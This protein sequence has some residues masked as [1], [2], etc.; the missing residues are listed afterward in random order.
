MNILNLSRLHI[1][2]GVLFVF[3]VGIQ[4]VSYGLPATDSLENELNAHI[5]RNGKDSIAINMLKELYRQNRY[6]DPYQALEYAAR[7]IRIAEHLKDSAE[8]ANL[9]NYLGD[10]HFDRKIYFLAMDCYSKAYRIFSN[11]GYEIQ[12]AYSLINIG[13]TYAAQNLFENA[14][15]TYNDAMQIFEINHFAEGKAAVWEKEGDIFL[16]QEKQDKAFELFFDVLKV[17]K[18]TQKPGLIAK[19]YMNL[20]DVFMAQNDY[21]LAEQNLL[22][23]LEIYEKQHEPFPVAGIYAKFGDVYLKQKKYELAN[24]C[25]LKSYRIYH[26]LKINSHIARINIKIGYVYL[27]R[28]RYKRAVEHAE[29]ALEA[30]IPGETSEELPEQKRD[31]Y[32]LLSEIFSTMN[33]FEKALEYHRKYSAVK[34]TIFEQI[35]REQFAEFQANLKTE[36]LK[37]QIKLLR[38]ESE[39]KELLLHKQRN[40]RNTLIIAAI[41]I[42]CIALVWYIMYRGK[43]KANDLLSLK[44]KKIEQQKQKLETTLQK[45]QTSERQLREA[46]N[47]KDKIFSIIGHDLRNP[48]GT[49]RNML[50]AILDD[51]EL[52]RSDML[53]KMLQSLHQTANKTYDLLENLLYWGKNQ[54]GKLSYQPEPFALNEV[55]DECNTLLTNDAKSKSIEIEFSLTENVRVFADKNMIKTVIRNL[56]TNAIKFTNSCGKISIAASK[57]Q[58]MAFVS[59]KDNGVGIHPDNLDK[60][61]T[62]KYHFTTYGT[63]REK[64]SGLGLMLCKEFVERNGGEINVVTEVNKGSEFIFSIPLAKNEMNKND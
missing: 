28:K 2:F 64:G 14:K 50:E 5:Q 39:K 63:N 37:K 46:N 52:M 23:A 36:R 8:I 10:V 21:V 43:A 15:A 32:L 18:K 49:F 34:D 13:D 57:K 7:A 29:K 6:A 58:R 59:V 16:R 53:P 54:R 31:A 61:F 60:L 4:H 55:I 48:I 17:R 44:N 40:L 20:V 12:A 27:K 38:L 35:K 56:F 30:A 3:L 22:N 41:L 25:L 19:S 51:E 45:L 24:E 9:N 11:N 62:K 26:D 1:C 33:N 42:V 47:A